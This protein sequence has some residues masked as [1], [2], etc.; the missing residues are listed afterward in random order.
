M[1]SR[2][3]FPYELVPENFF[4]KSVES[5]LKKQSPCY[6]SIFHIIIWPEQSYNELALKQA[7]GK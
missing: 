7:K 4:L 3:D 1:V 6:H 2:V 5:W